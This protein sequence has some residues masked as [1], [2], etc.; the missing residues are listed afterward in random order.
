MFGGGKGM[1]GGGG[2][3][4]KVVGRAVTR[5]GVTNL[6]ETISSSSSSC[7]TAT[8]P[9]AISRSTHG[10]NSSN[11]NLSLSSAS[12]CNV[13]VSANY[14]SPDASSWPSFAP[15]DDSY[16]DE[17]EWVYMDGSEYKSTIGV[18]D[19]FVLGP[20]PS[21]D[22]VHSAVS[23]LTQIYDAASHPQSITDKF[24]YNVDKDVADQ[25]L[26]STG[27]LHHV[28]PAGSDLDWGESSPHLCN[29]RMLRPYGPDSVYDAFH[30]LQ[31]EPS[32]QRMVISLSSDKAVWDA[33]L[34]NEVVREL[35]ET[36][37]AEEKISSL[38]TESSDETGDDSSPALNAVKWIFEN[39]KA[40]FTEAIEKITKL[41]NE[42]FKAPNNEK[43]TTEA[44]DPFEEKL[45]TSFLL[46]VVVLL[47]VVVTRAHR[48]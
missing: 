10:L 39:T 22:E 45:R 11:N 28:S 16:S 38:T 26:S 37:C 17:Y 20:V 2:S 23:A 32:V 42:L 31:T 21:M 9:T 1:G 6:Q 15:S 27:M 5:A 18:S 19:D 29:S 8:S 41:M 35:R 34:N 47:V 30:L 25:I 48:A 33:V 12:A 13:P 24:T 4:L 7:G 3:M 36:Y 14:G 44:A 40:K 43:K 46:S